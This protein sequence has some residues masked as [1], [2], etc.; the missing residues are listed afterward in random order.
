MSVPECAHF[1]ARRKTPRCGP[2]G[3]SGP[4]RRV[5]T[6]RLVEWLAVACAMSLTASVA[7]AGGEASQANS[8]KKCVPSNFAAS[9]PE[10]AIGRLPEF[11]QTAQALPPERRMVVGSGPLLSALAIDN[12]CHVSVPVYV[13]HGDRFELWHIFLLD[14]QGGVTHVQD[15]HG[16][17]VTLKQ[18]RRTNK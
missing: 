14:A 12:R 10:R 7:R 1:V 4:W 6:L 18:W 8:T 9:N 3:S 2:S 5:W 13:A 11:G 17:Y 16:N 15:V